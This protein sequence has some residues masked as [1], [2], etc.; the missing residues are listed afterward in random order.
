MPDNSP[1][2]TPPEAPKSLLSKI[3][4]ALAIGL[5]ALAATFGSMSAAQLQQALKWKA[6]SS[7][8]QSKATN[9]W[10]LAGFKR[11]RA[12]MMQTTAAVL[13][14]T[15]EH[16]PATFTKP[17]IKYAKDDPAEKEKADKLDAL[18]TKAL[19]WLT[20]EKGEKAG[21]PRVGLPEITDE[22]IKALRDGIEARQPEAD[23][24]ALAAKVDRAAMNKLIDDS[25]KA[26]EQY[27]KEWSPI[28]DQA[29]ALVR[30]QGGFKPD[31]P[32]KA[33][34]VANATAAQAAGFELEQRRYR[35]ESRLNQGLGFLYEIRV[36]VSTAQ[37][38]IHEH[39]SI[40]LGYA[41]LVAQIGAVCASLAMARKG[42]VLWILVTLI[43]FGAVGFG[44][45]SLLPAT[46]FKF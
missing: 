20:E 2:E 44:A 1:A 38:E 16:I 3:G 46:L 5:T 6:Q 35:L 15:S 39:K 21:P 24:L 14:A 26:V 40:N 42:G 29:A 27:D 12:M 25:E 41:M 30:M 45:Y 19:G 43:G 18:Q 9:Q 11:D 28:L 10:S 33:K 36:K 7:I 22:N 34:K 13:R 31:D 32:E 8:D 4:P 23:L 17:P 37:S